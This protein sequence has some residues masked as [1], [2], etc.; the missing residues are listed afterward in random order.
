MPVWAFMWHPALSLMGMTSLQR[1]TFVD[2][3]HFNVICSLDC[4]CIM[5]QAAAEYFRL[6]LPPWDA[7][8]SCKGWIKLSVRPQHLHV[9]TLSE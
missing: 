9:D 6:M 2:C 8:G 4:P 1:V 3:L 7:K 5:A